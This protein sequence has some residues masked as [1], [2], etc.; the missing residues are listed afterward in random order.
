MAKCKCSDFQVATEWG[1]ILRE[2]VN[3]RREELN[4]SSKVRSN[5]C[6]CIPFQFLEFHDSQIVWLNIKNQLKR[7]ATTWKIPP[8]PP[9]NLIAVS[10]LSKSIANAFVSNSAA[11]DLFSLQYCFALFCV[12]GMVNYSEV[13]GYPLVQHWKL[14]SI[15]YHVR[16]NQWTLSQ[17]KLNSDSSL[18][19]SS[20]FY[21]FSFS[22]CGT[23]CPKTRFQDHMLKHSSE[24][25]EAP[26]NRKSIWP[27]VIPDVARAIHGQENCLCTLCRRD[28]IYCLPCQSEWH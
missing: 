7:L 15:L 25:T 3:C 4:Q 16:L 11:F 6:S 22:W 20:S 26:K 10:L 5:S 14:R 13:S 2:A 18:F 28:G 8:P 1:V 19:F 24:Q 27:I 12:S 17:G 21:S 23:P 9:T